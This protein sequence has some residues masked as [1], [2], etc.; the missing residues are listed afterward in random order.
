MTAS[1]CHPPRLGLGAAVAW[2]ATSSPVTRARRALL[3]RRIAVALGVL[4]GGLDD[5]GG[6]AF[7]QAGQPLHGG[8]GVARVAFVQQ[9]DDTPRPYWTR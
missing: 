1:I 4:V 3:S 9:T 5:Q 8:G 6:R 2:P 7:A